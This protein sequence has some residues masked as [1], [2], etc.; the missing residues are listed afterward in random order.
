[1][2]Q[3]YIVKHESERQW[4][5]YELTKRQVK[6]LSNTTGYEHKGPYKSLLA[7]LIAA[8]K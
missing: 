5:T 1:M 2:K 6:I 3:W 7:C 8:N 4:T